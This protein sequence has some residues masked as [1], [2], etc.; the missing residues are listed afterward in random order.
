MIAKRILLHAIVAAGCA[1][2]VLGSVAAQTY[3]NRP[4][5]LIVPS[6]PGGSGDAAA[7]LIGEHLSRA[8]GQQVV[9]DNRSGANANIGIEAVARSAPDGYTALVVS[10]RVASAP[11]VF[12]SSIDPMKELMPVIQ[13]S[14][15]PVV[16]AVHPSLGVVSLAEFL[17]LAKQRPGLSYATSGVANQQHIVA[18]WFARI[19][20]IKL[21]LV[22][23]RGGGQ[24]I[25]DLIAGHVKVGSLGSTPLIPHHKAG[26]LRLL[27][28]STAARSLSLPDV[29]TYEEAG[30]KGL[31]LDQWIGVFVA[32]ATPPAITARLN[33]EINRALS[34]PQIRQNLLQQAQEPVGGTAEEFSN[35]VRD[36]FEK[37]RRL[38]K[39]LNIKIE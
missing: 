17:T 7:R 11:H 32:A 36:D 6:P 3:P 8:L 39:E 9:V 12:K 1:L 14:R 34:D 20:G 33:I 21:E 28:Q 4:I 26:T 19:A 13:L 37:Y 22:P 18:E 23:Y 2:S 35:L 24:A 27:V 25:N 5:R 16:L 15:Q 38:V 29:P 30:I 10:D 31:V